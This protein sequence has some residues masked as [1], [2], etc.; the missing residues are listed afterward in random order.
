MKKHKYEVYIKSKN[1]QYTIET[2]YLMKI[3]SKHRLVW[4]GTDVLNL[5]DVSAIFKKQ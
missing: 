4:F 2:D 3:D 5:D 1:Y